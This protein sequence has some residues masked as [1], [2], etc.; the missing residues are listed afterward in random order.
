MS[1][2]SGVSPRRDRRFHLPYAL[3]VRRGGVGVAGIL[4]AVG[5]G[6]AWQ[7]SL[8]DLGGFGLPGPGFFPLVL[9]VLLAAFAVAIG[10]ERWREAADGKAVDLG[11]RDVLIVF[12]ALLAVPVLFELLGA[13]ITLGLFGAAL[14]VLIARA[15]LW[16]AGLAAVI[17]MAGCWYFFEVLLG[18]Q[19]PSGP[20]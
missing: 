11:H 7:A 12:A 17:A 20:F 15:R 1:D 5:V 4:A 6:F 8:L 13:K 19:L 9:G 10:V 2:A 3:C 16:L 14:L 18:L